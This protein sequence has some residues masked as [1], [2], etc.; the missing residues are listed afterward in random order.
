[1]ALFTGSTMKKNGFARI[2]IPLD[3]EVETLL[4]AEFLETGKIQALENNTQSLILWN[5][6][7]QSDVLMNQLKER[8][9]GLSITRE[10][11]PDQDWNRTWIEGFKPVKTG[12]IWIS[13]PWHRDS[14]PAGDQVVVINPGSAFGTG[15]HEST[16]LS[17]SLLQKYLKPGMSVR[18]LGCGSGI[19]AITACKR[20]ADVVYACD[21]DPQIKDNIRENLSLNDHPPVR[22]EIRNA[23]QLPG[24]ACDL[25]LVN[26]QKPVIFPLVE[27]FAHLSDEE[28]PGRLIIAGLLK[29]DEK[30]LILLLKK[31]TYSI[32]EIQTESEWLAVYAE[33]DK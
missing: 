23:L 6:W 29:K 31:A 27:K 9:S 15:T 33:R 18:D 21:L 1:M 12:N 26:I 10:F 25:A 32:C 4:E 22:W 30:E 17:L 5:E 20:G 19:L 24:Y 11:V 3:P 28:K 16:R 14:I 7:D 8:F 2:M 13:P